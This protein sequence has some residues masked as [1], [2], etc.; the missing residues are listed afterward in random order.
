VTQNL[1]E[2]EARQPLSVFFHH[3]QA[4]PQK[5]FLFSPF[6][7]NKKILPWD[8]LDHKK[9]STHSFVATIF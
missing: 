4:L 9:G 5:P 3:T 6:F 8:Y 1:G 7:L 2:V